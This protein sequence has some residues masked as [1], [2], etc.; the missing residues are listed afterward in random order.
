MSEST[1]EEALTIHRLLEYNPRDGG[2][3]RTEENP[4]EADFIIIDGA[5]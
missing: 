5:G 1:G 3:Q 4:L 2:F